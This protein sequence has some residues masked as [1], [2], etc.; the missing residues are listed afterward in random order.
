MRGPRAVQIGHCSDTYDSHAALPNY[1][2][3]ATCKECVADV[4]AGRGKSEKG[5]RHL[6]AA[7]VQKVSDTLFHCAPR[8]QQP[9]TSPRAAS[10]VEL[11]RERARRLGRRAG[12]SSDLIQK[13]TES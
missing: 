2:T 3:H 10:V 12:Q 7:S 13:I 1:K 5:V 9:S 6:L 11:Q 8:P 4:L